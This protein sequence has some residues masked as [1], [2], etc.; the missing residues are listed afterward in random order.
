MGGLPVIDEPSVVEA[1]GDS[2]LI[3]RDILGRSVWHFIS[4][5]GN[6]FD[7]HSLFSCRGRRDP[8]ES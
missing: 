3:D 1:Q 6:L 5:P 7:P 4:G 2:S 8:D